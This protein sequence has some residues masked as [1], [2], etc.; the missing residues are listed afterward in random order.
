L[1]DIPDCYW[2]FPTPKPY[3][4]LCSLEIQPMSQ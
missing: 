4:V 2:T 3:S 1:F